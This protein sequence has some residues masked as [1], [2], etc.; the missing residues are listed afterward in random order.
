MRP[1]IWVT[2]ASFLMK[3]VKSHS[4]WATSALSRSQM[5]RVM[6]GMRSGVTGSLV[7]SLSTSRKRD[8]CVPFW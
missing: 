6:A 8:M 3:Y 4:K 1:G 5:A 2:G 7:C